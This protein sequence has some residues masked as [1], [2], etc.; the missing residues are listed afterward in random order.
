M[1]PHV[2]TTYIAQA[3]ALFAMLFSAAACYAYAL[4]HKLWGVGYNSFLIGLNA[5]LFEFNW[6][7]RREATCAPQ[8]YQASPGTDEHE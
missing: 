1:T 2:R 5:Y 8:P 6:R 7:M 4:D 3:V